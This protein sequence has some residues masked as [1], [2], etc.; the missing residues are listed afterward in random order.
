VTSPA[1]TVVLLAPD[2]L[3]SVERTLDAL[4]RQTVAGRLEVVVVAAG[5]AAREPTAR[6]ARRAL[7]VRRVEVG[8]LD[9]VGRGY[10]EGIRA[11]GAPVVALG[12]DHA[13]PEPGWAEALLA[14]HGDGVGA[15]GSVMVN[16]NPERWLSW[17]NL[18]VGYGP[19]VEPARDG[20]MADLPGANVSYPTALLRALDGEDRAL[21][22]LLEREGGL[23]AALR[24]RGL[25]LVLAAG[26]RTQHVN[27]AQAGATARLRFNV[28]RLYAAQR[29]QREAWPA[30]RR[31]AYAAA[32]PLIPLVRLRREAGALRRRGL[33]LRGPA[34]AGLVAGL[35]LDGAGQAAGFGRGPGRS[36]AVLADFEFE[37]E[38][39]A[40][41]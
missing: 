1:L 39:H 21:D 40:G 33:R 18:L 16:A 2:E 31:A 34:L 20:E 14:A 10:A 23:H 11:A 35:A 19:W 5:A 13:F 22:R 25:R 8:A 37:R 15:V 4:E 24:A 27:V 17:A 38:R 29:A 7:P 6:W 12:E 41:R 32:S 30:W 26:A 28:G 36:L 3:A 9:G